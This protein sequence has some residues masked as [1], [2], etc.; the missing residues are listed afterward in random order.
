MRYKVQD[1]ITG[2]YEKQLIVSEHA[3]GLHP[4]VSS[5]SSIVVHL[6]DGWMEMPAE[7][8]DVVHLLADIQEADAA[9]DEMRHATCDSLSGAQPRPVRQVHKCSAC[10]RAFLVLWYL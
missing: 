2:E 10:E 8:G 3:P 6:Q 1:I 9:A 7:V 4:P 5:S